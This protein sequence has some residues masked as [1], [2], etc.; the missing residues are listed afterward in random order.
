MRLDKGKWDALPGAEPL[1][2][3]PLF[4]LCAVDP[5]CQFRLPRTCRGPA[6]AHSRTSP[7]FSA[8]TPTH[9][10]QLPLGAP[11]A[12][13]LTCSPHFAQLRPLSRSAHAAKHRRRPAAA[14]PAILLAGDRAKPPRALPR[15]ETP[16]PVLNFPNF[17]L[18]WPIFGIAGARPWRSAAPTRWPASLARSSA[19][20]RSLCHPCLC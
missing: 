18:C 3:A 14:S 20:C 12:P 7:E 19:R 13:T 5:P 9:A 8:T 17:A 4:S 1:P 11:L 16:L 6:C 2:R 10:P 15:G